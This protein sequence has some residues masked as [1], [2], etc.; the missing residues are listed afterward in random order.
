MPRTSD[1]EDIRPVTFNELKAE[2]KNTDAKK[3][4]GYDLI[5]GQI[6]K[7]LP[8]KGIRKLLHINK[9]SP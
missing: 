9:C 8:E 2:I 7:E 5:T 6:I 3:A 4:P 1:Y